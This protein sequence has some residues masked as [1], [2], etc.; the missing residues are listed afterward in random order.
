M[1]NIDLSLKDDKNLYP[2]PTTLNVLTM[3]SP[4]FST[5]VGREDKAAP[6]P[7]NSFIGTGDKSQVL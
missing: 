4:Y 5:K 3:S 1:R 7:F 2:A 6:S